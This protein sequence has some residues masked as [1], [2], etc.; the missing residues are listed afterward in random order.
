MTEFSTQD[1]L[2]CSQFDILLAYISYLLWL[3]NIITNLTASNMFNISVSVCQPSVHGLFYSSARFQ[4]RC[5]LGLGSHLRQDRRRIHFQVHIVAGRIQ[6]LTGSQTRVSVSCW[7]SELSL[8]LY[9]VVLSIG[10]LTTWQ[11]SSSNP[12][13]RKSVRKTGCNLM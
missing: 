2:H 5:Q 13:E 10:Q 3:K 11:L 7:L 1:A 8:V 9:H 6:F 12:A 4:S